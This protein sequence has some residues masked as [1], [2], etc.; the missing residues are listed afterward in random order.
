MLTHWQ[1]SLGF[2]LLLLLLL[3]I[4][5]AYEQIGQR[6]DLRLRPAPGRLVSVGNHKLHLLCKGTVAPTVVIEQGAGELSSY[7]WALQDEIA[8]FASV[9]TYDRAGI[10]WSDSVASSRTIE[11]RTHELHTLLTNAGVKGP[12][13]FVAHSYGGL[14][15]RSYF[16]EYP[17]EVAG[18]ILVDTPEES[19]IFQD[20]V[21]DFYSKARVMQRAV[22]YAAQFGILRLLRHWIPLDRY[23]FWLTRFSEYAALCD[24]LASLER[25]PRSMRSSKSA[26]SFGSLPMVVITHGKPFPGPFDVL[27]KNWSNSQKQLAALSTDSVLIVA[28]NSNHMI[29]HDEPALVVDA[30]QS[31]HTAVRTGTPLFSSRDPRDK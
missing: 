13:I 21:L 15:V 24:D 2:L 1:L 8:K 25:V 27:E 6:R 23:G 10:G 28:E 4:G 22:G 5:Y 3:A 19:S 20:D 31:M 26:G 14:I 18:L 17:S 7:W 29:Q 16:H 12:Y 30:V 9:C 11:D